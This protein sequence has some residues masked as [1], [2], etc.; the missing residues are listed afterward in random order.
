M[1]SP[2]WFF[3]VRDFFLIHLYKNVLVNWIEGY[4]DIWAR[5]F[6]FAIFDLFL[7]PYQDLITQLVSASAFGISVQ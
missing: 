7:T 5:I 6:A 4:D 3:T 1:A 2:A